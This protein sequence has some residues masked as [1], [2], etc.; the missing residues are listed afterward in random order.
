LVVS[1][2]FNSSNTLLSFL[3]FLADAIV[4]I[5]VV[6][7]ERDERASVNIGLMDI[8]GIQLVVSLTFK[9]T[10]TLFS[11]LALLA[12]AIVIIVVITYE[13][14]E[15][16]SVDIGLMDMCGIQLVVSLTFKSTNKTSLLSFL[17]L[18]AGVIVIIVVIT[19]ERDER[20]SVNIG[21]MDI[22]GIQ[23]VVSLTFKSTTTLLSFLALL[24]G[25]IVIIVVITYER[26]E[27]ESVNIGL[28]D[29]CGIQLVVS[30]TFKSTT[31]LFSFLTFLADAIVIIVVV[32]YERDERASVN[33][34]L[35][36]IC[37]IQ[38]VVSFTFKSTTTLLSLLALLANAI[39][40]IVVIAYERDEQASVTIVLMSMRYS[41]G[42]FTYLQEHDQYHPSFLSYSSCWC[43]RHHHHRHHLRE[44]RTS[45]C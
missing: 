35:M 45:I 25:A 22:C 12:G 44:R 7:Y 8:C 17:T 36:D 38:L 19:Y 10:T 6:T 30:L 33:I 39:V 28:M 41:T 1:L 14:D 18:L 34:G 11:F 4:I 3:T 5:V 42:C 27:R 37:G 9:S 43:H 2:T 20:A 15:R 32:T 16:A 24:A 26:D 21:L 13:G 29:M 31:T 23:L 40:I